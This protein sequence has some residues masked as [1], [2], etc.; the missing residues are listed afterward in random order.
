MKLY[1]LALNVAFNHNSPDAILVVVDNLSLVLT[2]EFAFLVRD[3]MLFS[4]LNRRI[5]WV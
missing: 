4:G 5:F 1:D 2:M 3:T